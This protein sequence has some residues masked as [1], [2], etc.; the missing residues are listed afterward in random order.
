MVLAIAAVIVAVACGGTGDPAAPPATGSDASASADADA[1]PDRAPSRYGLDQRPSNRTC[2]APPRPPPAGPVKFERVFA[3][4][5]LQNLLVLAQPPGDPSRWYAVVHG[6]GLIVRFASASPTAATPA[7]DVGAL[8]GVPVSFTGEG[9]LLGAAFHPK[10]AQNGRLYVSWTSAAESLLG[11]LTSTDNGQT[12]TAYRTILSFPRDTYHCG[13]GLAFGVD[14]LLYAGFGDAGGD[15]N[16]QKRTGFYGKV[17]RLDIDTPPPSGSDYVIPDGNPFKAGGGEPATFAWGFR[18]PFRLSVDRATNRLWVGDVGQ[19]EWE[20]VDVV[21]AGENH[22]WPC[23]EG[24]HDFV[25]DN[26]SFCPSRLG[27]TDPVFELSHAPSGMR[28]IVGGVVYRGKAIPALVGSYVFGDFVRQDLRVLSFDATTGAASAPVANADGPFDQWV[29]FAEDADGEV[30]AVGGTG[31][32]KMVAAGSPP[33]ATVP[34]RLKDTGCFDPQDP[35]RPA[36]GLLPYDV[37]APF[38]SDG[39][40]KQRW[41][42]LPDGAKVRVDAQGHLELPIGSVVAKTFSFA[43]KR[44]ETR[45]FVRHDDGEW[46]GYSYEWSEAQDDATLLSSSKAKSIAGVDWSYPDRADC[47]RCH[48]AAAGRTL[49]LELAQLNRD[50]EYPDTRRVANQLLTLDHIGLF[51]APL[52]TSIEQVDAL[53]DPYGTTADEGRARA[54]LHVNCSQCHRPGVTSRAKLDLRFATSLRS[55]NA[56]NV[57]SLLDDLGSPTSRLVRPGAPA[58]SLLS[59][60]PHATDGK[61]MPPLGSGVVDVQGLASVDRWIQSLTQCP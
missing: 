46:A 14:G 4:L 39:A 26:E 43:G 28:A 7:A 44:V 51:D 41:L 36:P 24:A 57:P 55:M 2:K 19:N 18:N 13:G 59:L 29:D 8:A 61:R 50:F 56:C 53:P 27:L 60:R 52:G 30:Y 12:F 38:W 37:N 15:A 20:E 6:T 34:T 23:R 11:Y 16:A 31:V 40:Q 22:G 35:T 9:G 17:L 45:L 21:R 33:A 25:L 1:S 48:T 32:F 49:G 58:S 3:G 5:N 47:I 54:Y 10:F 42:A